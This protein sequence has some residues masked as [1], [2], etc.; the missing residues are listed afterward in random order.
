M[1]KDVSFMQYM[2]A[3]GNTAGPTQRPTATGALSGLIAFVPYEAI[4]R[5]SGARA[6]IANGFEI[7]EWAS[8]TFNLAVMI[9]AGVIYGAIFKRAANDRR[10]GWIFGASYGFLLWTIAPI[11]IWQLV[12]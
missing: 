10:G 11:T 3:H 2:R 9:I 12:A 7:S 4:L 1:A 6:S 5:L 8:S